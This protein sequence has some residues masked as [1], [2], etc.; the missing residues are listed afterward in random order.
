MAQVMAAPGLIAN[1]EVASGLQLTEMQ[2]AELREAFQLFDKVGVAPPSENAREPH[3]SNSFN[4]RAATRSSCPC[5]L[6][7]I[8]PASHPLPIFAPIFV[9]RMATGT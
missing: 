1:S 3:A 8:L 9:T 6:R 5:R 2:I 7:R 4:A